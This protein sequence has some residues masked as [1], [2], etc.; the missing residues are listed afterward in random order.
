M[1][2]N[3]ALRARVP[4]QWLKPKKLGKTSSTTQKK[5]WTVVSFFAGCGGL[6]LGFVGGF[7]FNGIRHKA[8]PFRILQAYDNDERAVETYR[9]NISAHAT[10]CD[11]SKHKPTDIPAAQVL[12]GGFPCQDFATC[13]PRQGLESERGR[14]YLA[15]V[16]YARVHRPKVIVAENV[17]GLAN[18]AGGA[19]L[20]QIIADFEKEGYKVRLWNL[21]GPDYGLPQRRTRLFIVGVRSDLDG[22]PQEPVPSHVGRHRTLRWAIEDLEEIKGEEEV[23]NQSQYFMASRAKRGNGQGDEVSRPDEPGYTV[24][25]NAKSRV[26]F[27]Y[28]LKRR[29][30]VRECARLQ[31]FPDQ[32]VFPHSATANVMQIGNAVPP[33]LSHKV[34][35]AISK[36]LQLGRN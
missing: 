31:T 17:P 15:L 21:Y 9:L 6:D 24:R 30:T 11:L 36:Y 25:A 12:I 23:P 27:H 28:K 13:G 2:R 4:A 33:M 32:F 34:A 29:L 10:V 26:Q 5:A 14:L 8:L 3:S 16:K 19:V 18:I 35:E 1:K 20:K 7:E 22:F